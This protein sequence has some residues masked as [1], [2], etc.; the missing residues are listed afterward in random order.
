[1]RQGDLVLTRI[2]ARSSA[3]HPEVRVTRY[4]TNR[5]VVAALVHMA[6]E[7][8][9]V[10]LG[11]HAGRLP[12]GDPVTRRAMATVATPVAIL[13]HRPAPAELQP[14]GAESA[15]GYPEETK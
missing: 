15:H 9:L 4:L 1:V 2:L 3:D 11:A 12:I 8:G 7:V 10:V 13:A 14:V 6:H 5:P